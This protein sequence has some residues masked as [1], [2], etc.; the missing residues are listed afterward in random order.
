MNSVYICIMTIKGYEIALDRLIA[1]LPSGARYIV[2]Y[3]KESEER[4]EII[5]KNRTNVYIKQNIFE[6]GTW[7]AIQY[8]VEHKVVNKS[9]WFLFTHDTSEFGPESKVL[10]DNLAVKYTD[11]DKNLIWLDKNGF[12]NIC[13]VRNDAI[14]KGAEKYKN[15]YT[16]DKAEAARMEMDKTFHLSPKLIDTPSAFETN[17]V[18]L[19]RRDVGRIYNGIQRSEAYFSSIGLKKYYYSNP[20][21]P[22]PHSNVP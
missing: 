18:D 10:I 2:V 16:M 1:S 20:T 9:D 3:G 13:L 6:Y 19:H 7:V 8:L 21:N 5:D 12:N 11:T 4:Y 14:T 15:I 17:D 22:V